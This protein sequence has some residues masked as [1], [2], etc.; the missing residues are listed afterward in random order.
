MYRFLILLI[1]LLVQRVAGLAQPTIAYSRQNRSAES[2]A[3]VT[4]PFNSKATEAPFYLKAYGFYG[5]LTPGVQI[6]YSESQSETGISFPF[7]TTTKGLGAGL[8]AGVGIGLITSDFINIGVDADMLFGSPIKITNSYDDGFYSYTNS[9]V[10][11][12]TVMSII[13]NITFKALSRPSYYIYN[14]LGLMGG[15]VLDYKT[16]ENALDVSSDG[17]SSSYDATSSY[18]KNSLALGYQVALGVQFRLSQSIR[19][20]AEITAYNQSF[21]PRRLE[22]TTSSG[23]SATEFKDEGTY[24][25]ATA[26]KPGEDL[27]FNVAMNSIGVGVGL[28]FRF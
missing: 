7:K 27:S 1:G 12:L 19:G 3:T 14:R 2:P 20:F 17:T 26:T 11:T 5:L 22:L 16:V 6:R 25:G 24:V 21:K 28:V 15:V 10:T 4:A 23:F 18:T 13:P 9:S 8:H